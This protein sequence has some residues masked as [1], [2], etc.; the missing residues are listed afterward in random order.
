MPKDAWAKSEE[1]FRRKHYNQ[2]A[3]TQTGVEQC[4]TTRHVGDWLHLQDKGYLR[5]SCLD[6]CEGRGG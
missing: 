6:R 2:E 3:L 1:D 5:L 4:A